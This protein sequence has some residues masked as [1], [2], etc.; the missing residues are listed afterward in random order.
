MS[1]HSKDA[2][3]LIAGTDLDLYKNIL[4]DVTMKSESSLSS[5]E[6]LARWIY[7]YARTYYRF[8]IAKANETKL[9]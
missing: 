5:E 7:K 4:K 9:K 3:D 8:L 2:V 1:I 6:M